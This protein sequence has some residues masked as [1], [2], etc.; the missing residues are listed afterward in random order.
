MRRH[1]YGPVDAQ[2]LTQEFF[3]RLLRYGS[4]ARVDR[5]QGKFRSFLLAALKHFLSDTL[6][7]ARAQKRGSGQV[8]V[9]FDAARAEG[10]YRLEPT[11]PAPP[12]TLF[13]RGWALT[14]LE[15]AVARLREEYQRAGRLAVYKQLQDCQTGEPAGRSYAD[16]AAQLGVSESAVRSAIYR[17]RQRHHE[18]V[19][20]EVARTV[21]DPAEVD[22]EIR[23][24][25]KAVSL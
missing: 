21:A 2:D 3:L 25:L 8:P 1:G 12:D 17:L 16:L 9:S 7:K 4:L 13:D 23:Y 20:E 14:L 19:R 24:L 11:A 18:L 10:R 22:A 6:D 5:Q 15:R